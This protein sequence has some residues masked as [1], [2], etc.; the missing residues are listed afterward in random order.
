MIR[1]ETERLRL[2]PIRSEDLSALIDLWTDPE[3]TCY[4]GGA[5]SIPALREALATDLA[6]SKD[7]RFNLW[8]VEEKATGRVVGHC[9]LLAKDID[10]VAEIELVYVFARSVWGG[11]YGVEMGRALRDQ[12]LGQMK[13][14]R[15]IALIH[16]ENT[17][18]ERVAAALGMHE[19]AEIVRPEGAVRKLYAILRRI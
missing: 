16:P 14:S 19:E 4:L 6:G 8:P 3:V 2:R 9:G 15:L 10:G 12:A 7:D 5:R 17:A 18:S 13:L 1:L 11:G